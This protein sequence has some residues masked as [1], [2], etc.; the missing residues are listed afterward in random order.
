M[1][2]MQVTEKLRAA[3]LLASSTL[4]TAVED[5]AVRSPFELVPL[6]RAAHPIIRDD[7]ILD[8]AQV[9]AIGH[10]ADIVDETRNWYGT[11]RRFSGATLAEK[12]AAA[13]RRKAVCRDITEL[14]ELGLAFLDNARLDGRISSR[15]GHDSEG[16]PI[17]FSA[18]IRFSSRSSDHGEQTSDESPTDAAFLNPGSLLVARYLTRHQLPVAELPAFLQKV[19]ATLESLGPSSDSASGDQDFFDNLSNELDRAVRPVMDFADADNGIRTV[20][21][22]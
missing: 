8:S 10:F 15:E 12:H 14:L 13:Q 17:L 20:T 6:V 19:A 9:R 18:E 21:R 4:P 22:E 11:T 1:S 2:E 5:I 16:F 7:D 3:R